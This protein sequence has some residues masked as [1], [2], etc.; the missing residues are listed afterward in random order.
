MSHVRNLWFF[1]S[2]VES[3]QSSFLTAVTR[4]L[5]EEGLFVSN[6]RISN[7]CNFFCSGHSFQNELLKGK[8]NFEVPTLKKLG[9][10]L[11]VSVCPSPVTHTEGSKKGRKQHWVTHTIKT[12]QPPQQK[13]P[14]PGPVHATPPTCFAAPIGLSHGGGHLRGQG[15]D[16]AKLRL[17]PPQW[18]PGP[19]GARHPRVVSFFYTAKILKYIQT[20]F[21]KSLNAL[22]IFLWQFIQ[23]FVQKSISVWPASWQGY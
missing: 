6:E 8:Q 2:L 17:P 13:Q 15:L 10:P 16:G 1:E 4:K 23:M 7:K 18:P 5:K 20:I 3:N 21:I 9:V 12:R 19:D 11:K 22:R 14:Q